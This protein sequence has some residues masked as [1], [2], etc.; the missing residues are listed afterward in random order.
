MGY[1]ARWFPT[2]WFVYMFS[3]LI[4]NRPYSSWTTILTAR[5]SW[6]TLAEPLVSFDWFVLLDGLLDGSSMFRN[7]FYFLDF[8]I[9]FGKE[10]KYIV[11]ESTS[12]N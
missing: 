5:K 11:V 2:I 7:G 4:C 3:E 12:R 10:K 6:N 8:H 9:L 1:S